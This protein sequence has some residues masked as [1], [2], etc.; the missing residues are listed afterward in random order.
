MKVIALFRGLLPEGKIARWSGLHVSELR[1]HCLSS[2]KLATH[3]VRTSRSEI[4]PEQSYLRNSM[5]SLY[6][7][8]SNGGLN[9]A[10]G[11]NIWAAAGARYQVAEA[12]ESE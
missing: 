5:L 1:E 3:V 2:L 8:V 4:P 9:Q 7:D 11:R 12:Y 10:P 6:R